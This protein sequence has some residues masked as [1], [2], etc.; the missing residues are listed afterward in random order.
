MRTA[1]IAVFTALVLTT[2]A[3]GLA[4]AAC[5]NAV[6][7]E[8]EQPGTPDSDWRIGGDGDPAIV[9]FGTKM[10][11]RAGDTIG[12]KIKSTTSN[13]HVDILRLGYYG[14][15][16]ARKWASN[17]SPTGPTTQS[18]CNVT[19]ATGMVDCGNWNT[20]LNWTV[21]ANAVSGVY[22]AHLVR[23]D[24]GAD[25]QIIFVVRNDSSHSD[26]VVQTSDSTWQAYNDY[27][28][29]SLYVCTVSCPAGNPEGYKAAY[30]V[31]YNRP[32]NNTSSPSGLLSGA[33]YSMIRWLEKSGYDASYMSSGDVASRGSTLLN[34]KLFISSGHDEYWSA[35]QRASMEAARDAGVNM[36][37]FSGNEGFWKTRWATD[38][39]GGEN[40]TL[41]SYKDSHFNARTDPVTWTGAWRDSRVTT[42]ADNMS[43]ANSLTG[44]EFLVN[45]G[46]SRITV[47]AAYGKLR[48]WR[49]TAAASLTTGQSLSLAPDTL[50]YEWDADA[51]NGFRPA[52][53]FRLSS[54]TVSGLQ[55]FTDYATNVLDGQS[56]THNMT[57]YRAPSGALVFG[58]GTVQWAWGLSDWNPNDNTPDKNMRQATVNLFADMGVQPT[59][60]ETDLQ[61]ATKTTDTTKPVSTITGAPATVADGTQ[62]TISGTA[63]DTGGVVAGVEVSTDNGSTW[64]PA[65]GTTSWSYS[66]L[67]H[68][69]PSTTIRTRATD[70]SGNTETPK[71]GSAVTVNCPCTLFGSSQPAAADSGDGS[72]IEVGMKFTTDSYGTV[73]GLRFYKASTNTGTHVGSL[74]SSD[75]TLLSRATFGS[76]SA[77]GWQTVS[78]SQPIPVLPGQTY[79]VSYFAPNGHYAATSQYFYRDPSPGPVGGAAPD[80]K[81]L[82]AVRNTGG[83]ENGVFN[84]ATSSTFPTTSFQASN[85][86]V[87]PV[88]T[89]QGPA[90]NVTSVTAS[91]TAPNTVTIN[92]SAPTSGGLPATY[93][94]TPYIGSAAQPTKTV[95]APATTTTI[96]GL[97][98]GSTYRFTVRAVNPSGSGAESPQS[99]AVTPTPPQAPSAPTA[100]SANAA[101]Q[102]VRVTW[103]LPA[104]DGG[105][106]ITQQTVT[107]YIGSA[108]QTPR[109][110]SATTTTTSF[111]GLTNGT[112]Y[113]Y[114][115]TATN[116]A[117]TSSAGSSNAATPW[118]TIFDLTTPTTADCGDS[119]S[120]EVG[121]RFKPDNDGA[122]TGVRFYKA[123]ANNGT[124]TGSLWTTNGTRLAQ[125]TFTNEDAG[126]WQ[127]VT[128]ADPVPVTAGTTYV[129]SYFAPNGHYA[130]TSNGLA[131]AVDNGPLHA[132]ANSTS[133]PNGLYVYSGASQFPSKGFNSSNYWV[134]VMYGQVVPGQVTGVDA[135]PAGATSANVTWNAPTTGAPPTSYKITAYA[136]SDPQVTKTVAAS[137]TATTV[138]GLTTG[139]AYTFKVAAINAAGSGPESAASGSVTPVVTTVPG[140]PSN[141][142]A[143][144]ASSSALVTWTVPSTDGGRPISG[145]TVTPYIGSVAQTPKTV[146][147]TAS[148]TTVTGLTNGESYTFKVSA[149]NSNGD[150]NASAASNAVTPR[151]TIFE[152]ADPGAAD[153]GDGSSVELGVKFTS[154]V[155]GEVRGIRFYKASTNTG[156]HIGSLWTAGGT[157]LAQVTFSDETG[158]GW[159]SATFSA[160][161]SVTAGTTYV[162]S[163]FAPNGHYSVTGGGLATAV[164]NAPLHAVGNATSPNG[165][166][167]YGS[168]STFPAGSFNASNYSVDVL[169][170]PTGQP[171]QPTGVQATAGNASANVSWTAP[172][173]S[174][175]TPTSYKV[176]P[177]VGSSSLTPTTVT[178]SP[179][180]TSKK[181]T[182]LTPGTSYTF[183]VQAVNAAGGGPDSAAS[184]AV[185]PTDSV[186][187]G[188]PTGVT[189]Q[190]DSGSAVV[191]WTGPDD[192]GGSPITGYSITPYL[193][194]VPQTPT[195]T[196]ASATS[197]RVTGLTRGSSYRFTVRAQNSKGLGAESAQSAA[198]TPGYSIFAMGTPA[199]A[200][201]NDSGSVVLGTR[202]FADNNGFI[203]GARFYKGPNNK[204]THVAGLWNSTGTLLRSAT[205]SNETASGW[206]T[207]MFATPVS[208]TANTAYIIGY[209]APQ[210]HYSTT[211][212]AFASLPF[213]SPPLHAFATVDGA[214]GVYLYSSSLAFPTNSFNATNY[215]AD[216]LFVP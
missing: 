201:A 67:A 66:W 61:A 135:Q 92:W 113:T 125:A 95:N 30:A 53:T 200:D 85:Y 134:D 167:A 93:V 15:D 58:A 184:N 48:M 24:T 169:F 148:S 127:S 38:S 132:L 46:T 156:T 54:T 56:A 65:T 199:N 123:A 126:G 152:F 109:T 208:I 191:G 186:V 35:S 116:S 63:S 105:A 203:T 23:N 31:S 14:G 11:V 16:G 214:N 64:H 182:G 117:G 168:S 1:L 149:T 190:A 120:L 40:R 89:A 130:C 87:D 45:A 119:S 195:T 142:V 97:T 210:G 60:R 78:F 29:N 17:L 79:V 145:Q 144:P 43:P 41:I 36:A 62:T 70:D 137:N 69:A 202:F 37:F 213:D 155:D 12:F 196:D 21:P 50:G 173:S 204:G 111:T 163:Y 183:T 91:E 153:G 207:V 39:A 206:Q 75:G 5:S 52:G 10:S 106:A 216:V 6:A 141:V 147:A 131:S 181:I 212:G 110:V 115:V 8:N 166:Y 98:A 28:G 151:L 26:V 103:T 86:W 4:Q 47:P 101:S 104:N 7:C 2:I 59:T 102:S 180:P 159:Q 179:L 160:P 158:S 215:W 185:V 100:V 193:G 139:T 165:L 188:A 205:F 164:D 9:G 138:T 209:L 150:G 3:P 33:E 18:A 211:A 20:T 25:N 77:S 172:G 140:T 13:F 112:T 114:K 133:A 72:G 107:P 74:W 88:F 136:G 197:V 49:N 73:S 170:R 83:V 176:T 34:H 22:I 154:D 81:P 189:A 143:R 124:H 32:L 55:V 192:D 187:P 146:S 27:G 76:E 175:G 68:G 174:G 71:P 51:D 82:H 94:V 57:L 177:H 99:N 157:R 122:V 129:A 162:A 198:V 178:G 96:N 42:A 171:A 19:A 108:A 80:G 84:Y 194:S 90:G 121:V 161:V 118:S 44:Q 128:F